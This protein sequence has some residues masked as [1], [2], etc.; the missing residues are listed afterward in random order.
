[1]NDPKAFA[2]A[3][4]QFH[5][6]L[7]AAGGNQTLYL[8]AEVLH[9]IVTS[10]V[11]RLTQQDSTV[12]GLKRRQKGIDAQRT[13]LALIAEGKAQEAEDF[14]RDFMAVSG[15]IMLQ[16]ASGQEVVSLP[17]MDKR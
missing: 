15:S 8:L 5:E 1:M 10:E 16:G 7:V 3:D 12:R 17:S 9:N 4:V 14:W 11:T 2:A 6:A 13:L